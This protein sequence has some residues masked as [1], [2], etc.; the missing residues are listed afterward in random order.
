MFSATIENKHFM[1]IQ[2]LM[3]DGQHGQN[4]RRQQ[5]RAVIIQEFRSGQENALIQNLLS[6]ERTAKDTAFI[7]GPY[8]CLLVVSFNFTVTI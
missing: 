6:A 5:K 8:N 3:E 4:G 7:R 2:H 1:H